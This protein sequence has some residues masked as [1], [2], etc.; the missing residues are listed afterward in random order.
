MV[1]IMKKTVFFG[2]LALCLT[3]FLV[4]SAQKVPNI[5]RL[6]KRG[7]NIYLCSPNGGQDIAAQK[8]YLIEQ[9]KKIEKNACILIVN[10]NTYIT[11][12]FKKNF[13]VDG[14]YQQLYTEFEQKRSE[15]IDAQFTSLHS[16]TRG[17]IKKLNIA[18]DYF[19]DLQTCTIE[20]AR[21]IL[22]CVVQG[23][24]NNE[25]IFQAIAQ[26]WQSQFEGIPDSAMLDK[27]L[28]YKKDAFQALTTKVLNLRYM[29]A[30][31]KGEQLGKHMMICVQENEVENLQKILSDCG[32]IEPPR[33]GLQDAC[34]ITAGVASFAFL[35]YAAYQNNWLGW[36]QQR[37]S[38][39][40]SRLRFARL[41]SLLRS[42][43]MQLTR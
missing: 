36:L 30:I 1:V 23:F 13:H 3:S 17:I 27:L 8:E 31:G 41:H 9:A 15:D 2:V 18:F 40:F 19:F 43:R 37:V 22:M 6:T 10:D 16:Q 7:L 20:H 4:K 14:R 34:I 29:Q 42:R 32:W 26:D 39:M 38:Y 12:E 35:A 11:D 25:Q 24:N 28:Q 21:E 33:F 5:Q